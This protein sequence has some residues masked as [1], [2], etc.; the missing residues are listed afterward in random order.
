[1]L[2]RY[3]V[4]E[5]GST[6]V[7][8]NTRGSVVS[9]QVQLRAVS[10]ADEGIKRKKCNEK[11]DCDDDGYNAVVYRYTWSADTETNIVA[12]FAC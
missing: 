6:L 1:V 8:E 7:F 3:E 11:Q 5:R 9:S 4:S 10:R 12:L 2:V